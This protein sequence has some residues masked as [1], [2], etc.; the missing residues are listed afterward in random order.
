MKRQEPES[1]VLVVVQVQTA[2]GCLSSMVEPVAVFAVVFAVVFVAVFAVVF[3][4]AFVAV[5]AVVFVAAFVAVEHY[6]CL[7]LPAVFELKL[8]P[9]QLVF[10]VVQPVSAAVQESLSDR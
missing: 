9:E 10:V 7:G 8:P 6:C 3:V 1:F 4:A 2:A 5:F